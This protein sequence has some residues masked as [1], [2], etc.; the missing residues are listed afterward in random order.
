MDSLLLENRDKY[1][2]VGRNS[3]TLLHSLY[4]TNFPNVVAQGKDDAWSAFGPREVQTAQLGDNGVLHVASDMFGYEF[5][6]LVAPDSVPLARY[7][8]DDRLLMDH[9]L[10]GFTLNRT[11]GSSKTRIV[12][13]GASADRGL[14]TDAYGRTWLVRSW[15]IPYSDQKAVV[16]ALPVPMGLVGFLRIYN[17]GHFDSGILPDMEH[18]ADHIYLSY[19]GT[20]SRWAEFLRTAPLPERLRSITLSY[21]PGRELALATPRLSLRTTPAVLP[22]SDRSDLQL[23]FSYF[24]DGDAVVWDVAGIQVGESKDNGNVVT[25]KRHGKPGADVSEGLRTDWQKIAYQQYPYDQT[26]GQSDDG[27]QINGL[28]PAYKRD[29]PAQKLGRPVL[30][31]TS[32]SIEGKQDDGDMRSKLNKFNNGITILEQ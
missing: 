22:I 7:Y 26:P 9:L 5:F 17:L 28:H 1:F 32:V 29:G 10:T 30:Y 8:D 4:A 13:L 16:Y 21:A 2:P 19:Y 6:Q 12:S 20:L 25:I 18:L 23:R 31:T 24:R 3:Q 27:T 15:L 14:R 11:I